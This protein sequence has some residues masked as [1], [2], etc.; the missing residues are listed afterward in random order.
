MS[1]EPLPDPRPL[2]VRFTIGPMSR[3]AANC[4]RA[5]GILVAAA[6]LLGL[7]L[8]YEQIEKHWSWWIGLSLIAGLVAAQYT[9]AIRWMD[10]QQAWRRRRTRV[11]V[12][13]HHA[14]R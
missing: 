1:Y 2:G 9:V 8:D 4:V 11:R 3:L 14:A 6:G 7:A 5:A 13:R 12:R 10:F